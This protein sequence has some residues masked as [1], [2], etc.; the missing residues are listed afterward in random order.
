MAMAGAGAVLAGIEAF[1]TM[2]EA[3]GTDAL[4]ASIAYAAGS[5]TG[6]LT[7][8]LMAPKPVPVLALMLAKCY[9]FPA[10]LYATAKQRADVLHPYCPT[11]SCALAAGPAC[12]LLQGE[13]CMPSAT[14]QPFVVTYSS[15]T[16]TNRLG[17]H[18]K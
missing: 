6:T 7:T 15:V 1:R 12:T 5:V 14:V 2:E 16:Y 11:P 8:R 13:R 17:L 4:R 9:T 10:W 18:R 3:Y